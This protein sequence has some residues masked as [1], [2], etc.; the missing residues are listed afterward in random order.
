MLGNFWE[1]LCHC[2]GWCW[3]SYNAAVLQWSHLT[4]AI[5]QWSKKME[6]TWVLSDVHLWP[7]K[8]KPYSCSISGFPSPCGNKVFI[9]FFFK[10]HGLDHSYALFLC[11]PWGQ[12]RAGSLWKERFMWSHA[13]SISVSAANTLGDLVWSPVCIPVSASLVRGSWGRVSG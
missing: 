1:K 3:P 2:L 11:L 7:L 9:F 10:R 12:R 13:G 8:L 4:M 6:R 5:L